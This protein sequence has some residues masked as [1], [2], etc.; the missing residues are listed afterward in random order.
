MLWPCDYHGSPLE[1]AQIKEDMNQDDLL[2]LPDTH[3]YV[4]HWLPILENRFMLEH[5]RHIM[6]LKLRHGLIDGKQH[7][8][9]SIG[10]H[11]E[12]KVP[13][14]FQKIQN[15]TLSGSR[16]RDLYYQALRKLRHYHGR[17]QDDQ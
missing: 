11:I 2:K 16:A 13:I 6:I 7:S 14:K 9:K 15:Q 10:N 17:W 3:E 5:K 8:F 12:T 1:D 4:I